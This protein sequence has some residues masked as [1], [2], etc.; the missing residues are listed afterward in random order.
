MEWPLTVADRNGRFYQLDINSAIK[1]LESDYLPDGLVAKG[2]Y[3]SNGARFYK[4]VGGQTEYSTP[5]DVSIRSVVLSE[6]A[7]EWI[8]AEG[9]RRHMVET[10][11]PAGFLAKRVVDDARVTWGYHINIAE[12]RNGI[13]DIIEDTRAVTTHMATS[14]PMLGGGAVYFDTSI[15]QYRYSYG[16]KVLAPIIHDYQSSTTK[17]KPLINTKEEALANA[18]KYRRIHIV[19]VDPHISPWANEMS[20]GTL[21]LMLAASR[22][23]KAKGLRLGPWMEAAARVSAIVATDLDM[24]EKYELIGKKGKFT[25][26]EI[27]AMCI[28][29]ANKVTGRTP[30]LDEILEQWKW[31]HD[32]LSTRPDRLFVSDAIRKRR[33]LENDLAKRH[34]TSLDAESWLKDLRYTSPFWATLAE[35]ETQT[36]DEIIAKNLASRVRAADPHAAEFTPDKVHDR[37][38]NPP[39]ESPRANARGRLIREGLV[40]GVSW[41][42]YTYLGKDDRIVSRE[43]DNPLCGDYNVPT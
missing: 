3:L 42:H 27:Q 17:A 1:L 18:E 5:E 16:Q 35:A 41:N 39:A 43:M 22:Q 30:E 14:L 13:K 9:L 37:V 28:E 36:T 4:D 19:G 25:A 33:F 10:Q 34:K 11:V 8:A 24:K 7:G 12:R 29:V 6:L 23:G 2:N 31:A 20:I 38:L 26:L 40:K 32:I 21:S 15:K